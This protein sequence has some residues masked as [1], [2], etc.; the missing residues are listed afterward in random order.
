V[1]LPRIVSISVQCTDQVGNSST[2]KVSVQVESA[3]E[4]LL[5]KI[6]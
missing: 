6:L 2:S 4:I 5:K 3:L 1:L